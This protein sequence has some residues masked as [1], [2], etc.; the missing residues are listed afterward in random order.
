ML[1]FSKTINVQWDPLWRDAHSLGQ[2]Q[3]G[4]RAISLQR[5]ELSL[6]LA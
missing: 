4:G 5:L 1:E 6:K 2:L 3:A